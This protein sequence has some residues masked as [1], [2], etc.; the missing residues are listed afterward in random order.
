MLTEFRVKNLR[1]LKDTG[2]VKLSPI[3]IL[4]G[5]NSSG[6]STFLRTFPLLKQSAETTTRSS[7]LWF[8]KYV[9]FGD[10]DQ[11]LIRK[12]GEKEIVFS[13]GLTVPELIYYRPI[14]TQGNSRDRSTSNITVS[15]RL[16]SLGKDG[17]T[18][19]AGIDLDIEGNSVKI[20][21]NESNKISSIIINDENH[22]RFCDSYTYSSAVRL[23]PLIRAK[24]DSPKE[25]I[26][27]SWWSGF[28]PDGILDDLVDTLRVYSNKRTS[29]E[30]LTNAVYKA[31]IGRKSDMLINFK[32]MFS[33]NTWKSK[34]LNAE[35]DDE[36]FVRFQNLLIL[37]RTGMTLY[38][39]DEILDQTFRRVSYIEPIRASAQRYYRSQDIGVKELDSK[40]ENLAMFLRNLSDREK[41][42]LDE[43]S[44]KEFGFRTVVQFNGG[45]VNLGVAFDRSKES[46]NLADMGFGY[47]Q[48]IPI[49][50]QLWTI[51]HK[52]NRNGIPGL[53]YT[54]VIEQPELHLHPRMQSKLAEM[55][56][57]V[58]NAAKEADVILH[59]IIET[60]SEVIV[61]K[62]GLMT[63]M[64]V[65]TKDDSTIVLFSKEPSASQTVVEFSGYRE[66]GSLHNW[67]YG[68][69]DYEA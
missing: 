30:S 59:L 17:L 10:F 19:T 7:I 62:I 24:S 43:W 42:A 13:F 57:S 40:G 27:R 16:A 9:D 28:W 4:L 48:V 47:S 22:S 58:V 54:C 34:T 23:L 1:S 14:R 67:P 52:P 44:M 8:G 46:Y 18:R 51:L 11:A 41:N 66:N 15:L 38:N 45:H 39:L 5:E 21:I 20:D 31:A 29:L 25:D 6:K 68:F 33:T 36:V 3:T 12:Q 63:A 53:S 2:T 60:H 55:L 56:V 50:I 61:N 35:Q 49:I 26:Y 64:G 32:K 37:A 65:L 69:F